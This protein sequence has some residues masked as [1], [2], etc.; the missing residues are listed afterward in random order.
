MTIL[1]EKENLI[2]DNRK[3]RILTEIEELYKQYNFKQAGE[4]NNFD[5]YPFED[6]HYVAFC[7]IRSD[8][9]RSN[10]HILF[11]SKIEDEVY[12]RSFRSNIIRLKG[13][14]QEKLISF[15]QTSERDLSLD[16]RKIEYYWNDDSDL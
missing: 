6:Y 16:N 13:L 5:N 2:L 7:L 9:F 4:D 11:P 12:D 15:S 1:N 14:I 8:N 10:L 3:I